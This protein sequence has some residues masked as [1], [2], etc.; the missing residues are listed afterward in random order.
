[1]AEKGLLPGGV[2][3]RPVSLTEAQ[4]MI[5]ALNMMNFVLKMRRCRARVPR[6]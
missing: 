6:R 5:V 3:Q 2:E 1:M 4:V